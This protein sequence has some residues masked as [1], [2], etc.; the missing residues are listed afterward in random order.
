MERV[1]YYLSSSKM[2][3]LRSFGKKAR[4]ISHKSLESL[5]NDELSRWRPDERFYNVENVSNSYFNKKFN[6]KKNI[7]SNYRYLMLRDFLTYLPSNLLVK[8]DRASMYNSLELRSPFLNQDI[9][10]ISRQIPL[11][12]FP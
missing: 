1:S 9:F 11:N 10:S 7:V 4:K 3:S 2:K 6:L 5:Y 8:T 12:L